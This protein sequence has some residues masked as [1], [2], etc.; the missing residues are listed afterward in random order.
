LYFSE[1]KPICSSWLDLRLTK[2]DFEK[3]RWNQSGRSL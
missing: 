2:T 3:R 1:L